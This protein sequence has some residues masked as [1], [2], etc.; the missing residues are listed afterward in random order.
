LIIFFEILVLTIRVIVPN[1]LLVHKSH[2][3]WISAIYS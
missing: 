2:I 3:P 1:G